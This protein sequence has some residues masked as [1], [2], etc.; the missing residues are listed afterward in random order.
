MKA[1]LFGKSIEELSKET[2]KPAEKD[3]EKD[4]GTE[5]NREDKYDLFNLNDNVETK[6]LD[7]L[8]ETE[9]YAVKAVSNCDLLDLDGNL[10]R[11]HATGRH[12][13]FYIAY[14]A[15]IEAGED[16]ESLKKALENLREMP[17]DT[18]TYPQYEFIYEDH[19]DGILSFRDFMTLYKGRLMNFQVYTDKFVPKARQWLKKLVER[20][21]FS[22]EQTANF[23]YRVSLEDT[24]ISDPQPTTPKVLIPKFYLK[25]NEH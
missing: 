10:M 6:I 22:S 17:L 19:P 20:G 25:Q 5:E 4:A 18:V 1:K 11:K 9:R 16:K 2:G 13:F 8:S 7:G 3:A 14:R 23:R 24:P 15:I 21:K 12:H